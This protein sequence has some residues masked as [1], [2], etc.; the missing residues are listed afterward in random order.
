MLGSWLVEDVR[1]L[2]S[3]SNAYDSYGARIEC[4]ALQLLQLCNTLELNVHKSMLLIL[5]SLW[6]GK[7]GTL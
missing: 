4:T 1:E 6:R 2:R 7:P 5:V 3:M